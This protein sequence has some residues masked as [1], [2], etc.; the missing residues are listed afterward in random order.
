MYCEEEPEINY[1]L[2]NIQSQHLNR[3]FIVL[4]EPFY[5]IYDSCYALIGE[6]SSERRLDTLEWKSTYGSLA[7]L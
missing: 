3:R 5:Y 1:G 4:C 7:I 2:L 6:N